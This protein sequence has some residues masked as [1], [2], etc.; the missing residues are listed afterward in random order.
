MSGTIRVGLLF[1]DPLV[2]EGRRMLL[3]TQPQFEVVWEE[4]DGFV[5]SESLADAAVDVVLVDN[6][7]KTLSGSE[8]IRRFIRRNLGRDGKLPAF[9]LT[10]PFNSVPMS[11]EAI[12]CGASDFVSEEET[13]EEIFHA[14][15]DAGSLEKHVDFAALQEFFEEAGVEHGSNQRWVFRLNNLNEIEQRVFEALA[16]A[17]S[18][19][20]LA[21]DT[22]LTVTRIG[23]ILDSF[24][25]K[26]GV[27]TRSQLALALH[28]AGILP[29]VFEPESEPVAES[30]GEPEPVAEIAA[31]PEADAAEEPAL[32]PAE[33]AELTIDDLFRD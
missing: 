29:P 26:L 32:E 14:V 30:I 10:G 31:E 9:V 22:E 21:Q 28:E 1:G 12:R 23:W 4:S 13:A 16:N 20:S 27:V 25:E 7:L 15:Q 6:R 11:L 33:E 2:R 19:Q 3:A 17:T 5:A 18:D 8:S 24:Q